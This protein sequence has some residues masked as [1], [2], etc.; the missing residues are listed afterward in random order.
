MVLVIHGQLVPTVVY[1]AYEQ[2]RQAARSSGELHWT[3]F[4]GSGAL[5][6]ELRRV[7]TEGVL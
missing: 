2:G 6:N 1:A 4:V 7:L 5:Q 3:L